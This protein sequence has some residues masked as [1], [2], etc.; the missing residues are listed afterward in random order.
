MLNGFRCGSN[1]PEFI[2]VISRSNPT[3][4]IITSV[5]NAPLDLQSCSPALHLLIMSLLHAP[6]DLQT[7]STSTP[8]AEGVAGMVVRM[9]YGAAAGGQQ[10]MLFVVSGCTR[11]AL[12][13]GNI[14]RRSMYIPSA[15]R[16]D[17]PIFLYSNLAADRPPPPHR[18]MTYATAPGRTPLAP[19]VHPAISSS[20]WLTG[21]GTST[22]WPC[23]CGR[24]GRDDSHQSFLCTHVRHLLSA[25]VTPRLCNLP[26]HHCVTPQNVSNSP[27]QKEELERYHRHCERSE[28]RALSK[29]V[30]CLDLDL[31]LDLHS[32]RSLSRI[33]PNKYRMYI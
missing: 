26:A 17:L 10:Y 5:L 11:G 7:C 15:V 24:S 16:G 18:S 27:F 33:E 14:E 20:C 29:Q 4:C 32:H 28:R 13:E 25:F 12:G 19:R 30:S 31:D 22:P 1:E 23:R 21:W 9:A 6:L 3:R 2:G 8:A